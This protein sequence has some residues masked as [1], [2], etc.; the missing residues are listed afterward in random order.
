MQKL[1]H[2]K[3]ERL[4]DIKRGERCLDLLRRHMKV[5]HLRQFV[6]L[7]EQLLSHKDTTNDDKF[8]II[9]QQQIGQVLTELRKL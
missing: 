6:V 4:F 5:S 1:L 3:N 9:S 7:V 8:N 2:I